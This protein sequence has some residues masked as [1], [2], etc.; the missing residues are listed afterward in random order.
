MKKT[1]LLFLFFILSL[2][3][4]LSYAQLINLSWQPIVVMDNQ[5]FPSYIWATSTKKQLDVVQ[6][7][8]K[9]DRLLEGDAKG[10]LGVSITFHQK[11]MYFLKVVIECDYIMNKSTYEVSGFQAPRVLKVFPKI[12]YK[13]ERLIKNMQPRPVTI[14]FHV[15]MNDRLTETKMKTVTLQ[16]VNECPYIFLDR[17]GYIVDLN[18]MYAAY[19]NESHP[20]ITREILP[21]I[22]NQNMINQTLGYL[23]N[24]KQVYNQV[25]AVWHYLRNRGIVYSNIQSPDLSFHDTYP[26]VC[27]QYVRTLND[28][29]NTSQANCVD[30]TVSMASILYRMGI[31]PVIVTTPT[32]CFL[33]FIP[34]TG[35]VDFLETTML[36]ANFPKEQ[37]DNLK[38]DADIFN[39]DLDEKDSESYRSFW[40]AII[41][42][43]NNY[44]QD[45]EKFE[46]YRL[47]SLKAGVTSKTDSFFNRIQYQI[48]AVHK[49]RNQG[50]L[51][52]IVE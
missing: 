38:I 50:L 11:G 6:P 2:G 5:L 52:I 47:T 46:S 17:N 40:L 15:Y 35:Q 18:F 44:H 36:S 48:Y 27:S 4:N 30:G 33:G 10:Q 39:N 25:F 1:Y 26:F 49:F 13:W 23:G 19:V 51:P 29:L 21:A 12:D 20:R 7:I 28:A 16:P 8:N 3:Q 9:S 31:Y 42:G 34:E 14:K 32:H 37:L 45:K 22:T 24:K 43:R 41:Q